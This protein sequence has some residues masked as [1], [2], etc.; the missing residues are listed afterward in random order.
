MGTK[1]SCDVTSNEYEFKLEEN[2][3]NSIS[4]FKPNRTLYGC[5]L[6]E[7]RFVIL[8]QDFHGSDM[9]SSIFTKISSTNTS[10]NSNNHR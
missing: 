6:N 4:R 10:Q 7:E 8:N 9:S 2:K 3:Q 5:A 1:C